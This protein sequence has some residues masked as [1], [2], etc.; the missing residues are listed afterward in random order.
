MNFLINI[1]YTT[2]SYEIS[3]SKTL[4]LLVSPDKFYLKFMILC[5]ST[6]VT[7]KFTYNE[8]NEKLKSVNT[9]K[10]YFSLKLY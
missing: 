7:A 8:Y 6:A 10:H 4:F 3:C 5:I 9:Q 2:T 1:N